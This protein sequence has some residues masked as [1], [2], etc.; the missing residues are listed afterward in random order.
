MKI[1]IIVIILIAIAFLGSRWSFSRIRLP[2]AAQHLYL[3]GTEFILVGFL[4]GPAGIN[5]FNPETV[6]ALQPLLALTLGWIGLLF[7]LQLDFK[8]LKAFPRYY[9][10]INLVHSFL[11]FIF[12]LGPVYIMMSCLTGAGTT[13]LISVSVIL[14]AAGSCTAQSSL[15]IMQKQLGI[16]RNSLM[17][18][19]RFISSVDAILA[20]PVCGVLSCLYAESGIR[21]IR[22]PPAIQWFFLS[23]CSAVLLALLLNT[24]LKPT[25]HQSEMLVWTVG[26]VCLAS[27][28]A[29]YFQLSVLFITALM[30]FVLANRHHAKRLYASTAMIEKPVYIFLLILAGSM[31]RSISMHS[32]WLSFLFVG[33]RFLTKLAGGYMTGKLF[34][35]VRSIPPAYGLGLLSEGGIS[36]A[37]A[38]SYRSVMDGPMADLVLIIILLSIL[39]NEIASS[40][41]TPLLIRE[42]EKA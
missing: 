12:T 31:V 28:L 40:I 37:I 9:V 10:Q 25:S 19:L 16:S 20:I 36:L 6:R 39:L 3:T 23:I 13:T 22:I 21:F 27:G 30:G 14:A 1:H 4:L 38:V 32:I 8:L 24:L 34:S 17:N 5:F 42:S 41:F 11:L 35:R 18:L 26:F 2:L 33:I 29:F 15:A 7:G